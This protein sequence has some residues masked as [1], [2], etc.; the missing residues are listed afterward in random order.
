MCSE[1]LSNSFI[2]NDRNVQ[3][4]AFNWTSAAKNG[5]GTAIHQ[6]EDGQC[7][8][9]VW[10]TLTDGVLTE[11]YYPD[12]AH[13][14]L[15]QLE[16]W[17]TDGSSF[18]DRELEDMYH[19]TRLVKEDALLYEQINTAKNGK[20]KIRKEWIADPGRDTVLVHI[21][22]EALVGTVRDYQ[23]WVCAKPI[24]GGNSLDDVA[25]VQ[26]A[27]CGSILAAWDCNFSLT[28][29]ATPSFQRVTVMDGR[30]WD[31]FASS[32]RL[33][34]F[35]S[36]CGLIGGNVV[37]LGMIQWDGDGSFSSLTLALSFA[38]QMDIAKQMLDESLSYSFSDL[39]NQ[40]EQGWRAYVKNLRPPIVAHRQQYY[41]AAMVIRAHEDK[42]QP[43]AIV[44]SLS[45][46]WGTHL[47]A[48]RPI[49]GY[50]LIWPRDLCEVASALVL[51]GDYPTAQRVL[52][53]LDE[54]LQRQDGSFPQNAWLDGSPYW[55]GQQLDETAFPILLAY[56]L[57][58]MHRYE[59]LV[60]PAVEYLLKHGPITE[61]ERW[62]ENSGYSPSTLATLIAALVVAAE[63]AYQADDKELA[64]I[65]LKKA[66]EWENHIESWTLS[67]KG[68]LANHPYYI[69]ISDSPNPD[70]GHW[71]ELKNGGGWH[72]KTAVVD[73]GFLELVRL[74]IRPADD[75][76]I[77][78][79]L[80]VIDQKLIYH[81]PSGP[82]WRRY[83]GDGYGEYEDGRPYDGAG[84]GRPWPLLCGERGE[85]EIAW[86]SSQRRHSPPNFYTPMK[87]LRVME[88]SANEGNL[89]PEQIWDQDE[90]P[91]RGLRR[92]AGTGS[93][94]PLIW[95]MAQYLRLAVCIEEERVV[96]MPEAVKKRYID[97]QYPASQIPL[98]LHPI[99][100]IDSETE[101][102]FLIQGRTEAGVTVVVLHHDERF[103]TVADT[104]GNFSFHVPVR[105][106]GQHQMDIMA[107]N[108]SY[109]LASQRMTAWYRPTHYY[110][111][112]NPD[113]RL[114]VPIL[115][116]TQPVFHSGDFQLLS[117]AV[118]ADKQRAYFDV[119][120]GHLDNP[121]LG[122]SGISKQ[123][124]DIY[125]DMDGQNGSGQIWTKDLQV[126]F[127]PEC[128]WEKMIRVTGNWHADSGLYNC[129]W[130]YSCKVDI[131]VEDTSRTIHIAIPLEKLGGVPNKGWGFMVFIAGEE[132]GRI[133]PVRKVPGDWH[134]GGGKD[135]VWGP[136]FVDWLVPT[137]SFSGSTFS[138][139]PML[140]IG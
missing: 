53:Y 79:S 116:P 71:I 74:G 137:N 133:R 97:R 85:Y 105:M 81:S 22:F 17:V 100:I 131:W 132:Y 91:L 58:A 49:G 42:Q 61:Q 120:L 20:Y 122:P 112:T 90:L 33:F 86:L 108:R 31:T 92:N 78:Q 134:F 121:W 87:L 43:G 44:A 26:L 28:I 47:P 83:N 65:C 88:N 127:A 11:V 113:S 8:S 39:K 94:T 80:N 73:A 89:I 62:E 115:Y 107:C 98:S 37:H 32:R 24:L 1:G 41:A 126:C 139:L 119:E 16:L 12:V 25:T 9:H 54:V 82:L 123:V 6:P 102:I 38:Q 101:S 75:L 30:A 13:P 52:A 29:G 45:I 138:A 23:L 46:P 10:F 64:I 60:K 136:Q 14:Q 51:I 2:F 76:S 40:Y 68:T 15:Q 63:M 67:R 96:E 19:E 95:A 124:I 57:Q 5:I 111:W 21:Q 99:S 114:E 27:K 18:I 72:E 77:V 66:D 70:D 48:D 106:M 55:T 118:G 50:H 140:R 7:P 59:S 84:K 3:R 4:T 109:S 93:A 129:D 103:S 125:I 56:Q 104:E 35:P 34:E 135:E 36:Q 117:V 110:T 128:G 69:R 130:S